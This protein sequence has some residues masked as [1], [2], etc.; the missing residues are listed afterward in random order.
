VPELPLTHDPLLGEML[1]IL[2]WFNDWKQ[3]LVG[4]HPSLPA[5][6]QLRYSLLIPGLLNVLRAP[7]RSAGQPEAG[8][9][10]ARNVLARHQ[11]HDP[12]L[13]LRE[14][15]LPAGV[16]DARHLP[17]LA[18]TGLS[19]SRATR[20]FS[21]PESGLDCLTCAIFGGCWD[22]QHVGVVLKDPAFPFT[23]HHRAPLLSP[24]PES[25]EQQQSE[26]L[27]AAPGCEHR[28]GRAQAR[29]R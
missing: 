4:H 9:V 3:G 21:R 22:C 10:P 14:P 15:H 26:S 12:G 27:R 28:S 24:T 13:G 6:M 23:G 25:R 2:K 5:G 11:D 16:P 20:F 1:D 8:S 29:Q 19:L 18:P 7:G 17:A